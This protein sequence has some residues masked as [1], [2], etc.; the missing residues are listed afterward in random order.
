VIGDIFGP[1]FIIVF[2]V[3]AVGLLVP[4]WAIAD[5]ASRPSG[6]FAAAGSSKPMWI[7]LIVVFWLITGVIGFVLACVYLASI[8]PRVKAITG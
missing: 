8:R 3:A 2:L 6:A 7:A 4:I 1:D 5:A